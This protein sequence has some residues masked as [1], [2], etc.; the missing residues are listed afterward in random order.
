MGNRVL[1]DF[2]NFTAMTTT[3]IDDHS[4]VSPTH[5]E[6]P[7][8]LS[9]LEAYV[10]LKDLYGDPCRECL[11]PTKQ[12]WCFF[13]KTENAVVEV[14]D[15]CQSS[16]SI[17][18]YEK[19][20][21]EDRSKRIATALFTDIKN[22]VSKRQN[23]ISGIKKTHVG[24]FVEN[25]F[26]LYYETA[27]SL[28]ALAQELHDADPL[29]SRDKVSA[30]CRSAFFQFMSSVEGLLNLIYEL[31]LKPELRV[32]RILNRVCREQVDLKILLMQ[33]YCNCF[34]GQSID[35]ASSVYK[36][37]QR[38]LNNRN[39]LVHANISDQKRVP[40]V[41][42]DGDFYILPSGNASRE[43]FDCVED[44]ARVKA[45]I[46]A[47]VGAIVDAMN[48]RDSYIFRQVLHLDRISVEYISGIPVVFH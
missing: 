35:S 21:D 14:Y 24:C 6:K 10:V 19:S 43:S 41:R 22:R 18:V 34:S 29:L 30:L 40:V 47:V 37:F 7:E 28:L 45:T 42:H 44:G 36:D 12:Q 38:L 46:D 11:D 32:D 48:P 9:S 33:V 15:Y 31:Y 20:K 5:L 27:K 8:D 2:P 3:E 17:S 39:D 23:A 4:L 25:P 16:W 26:S 13:L 1:M